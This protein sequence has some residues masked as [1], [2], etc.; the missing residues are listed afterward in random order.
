MGIFK[1]GFNV[2][3][4]EQERRDREKESRVGRLWRFFLKKEEEDVPVDFLT[5]EP[6]CFHEHTIPSGGG[7]EHHTCTGENCKFCADGT[8]PQFVAAWLVVDRRAVPYEDK[9]TGEKKIIK[10]RIKL[11]VRGMT[12]AAQLDRLSKKFGLMKYGWTVTRTG[13]G[14]STSWRF[15]RDEQKVIPASE[16]AELRKQLPEKLRNMSFDE[17][18]EIQVLG[19]PVEESSAKE[20]A[21]E[22]EAAL[23]KV[24]QGIQSL[25]EEDAPKEEEEPKP[26]VKKANA[27][28][29]KKK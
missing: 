4:E 5:E 15:E 2:I 10:D 17:I 20:E 27:K 1:R 7:Y 8:K 24:K 13:T 21:Q 11:L 19:M 16:I 29:I 18:I 22:S 9:K 23:E 6:L 26:A 3:K 12:D 14:T 28:V 25:D